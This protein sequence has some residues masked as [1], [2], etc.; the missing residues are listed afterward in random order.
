M[1]LFIHHLSQ[2][3]TTLNLQSNEIGAQGAEHLANALQENKV[4]SLRRPTSYATIHSSFITDTH[5]TESSKQ[6]DRCARRRTS[7]ECI[8]GKQGNFA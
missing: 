1:Q 8:A 2:T 6:R 3:L 4:T 5:N 7:C